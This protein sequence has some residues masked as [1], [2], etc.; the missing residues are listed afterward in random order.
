VFL[1]S[2]VQIK[3]YWYRGAVLIVPHWKK[4]EEASLKS[5]FGIQ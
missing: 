3:D 4:V 1:K 5:G 2:S